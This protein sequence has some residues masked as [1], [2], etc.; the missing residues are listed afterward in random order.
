MWV[1]G[2]DVE[3]VGTRGCLPGRFGL[4][5]EAA[6]AEVAGAG[7]RQPWRQRLR[8]ERHLVEAAE[9]VGCLRE[10]RHGIDEAGIDP[11]WRRIGDRDRPADG[12]EQLVAQAKDEVV[13]QLGDDPRQAVDLA[14]VDA[15][16]A[17]RPLVGHAAERLHLD[18]AA[19]DAALAPEPVRPEHGRDGEQ[20]EHLGVALEL[21]HGFVGVAT[22]E[23][24]DG[25]FVVLLVRR[26]G[27][28]EQPG[29]FHLPG[30]EFQG[31]LAVLRT[32]PRP[33]SWPAAS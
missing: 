20:L 31:R 2:A 33:S 7:G 5:V 26:H 23:G 8:I 1:E 9:D 28:H 30:R 12:L 17:H 4:R 22:R 25:G 16:V 13:R 32:V 24:L 18:H 10:H 11:E 19:A 14:D 15:R 29:A 6:D 27:G 21:P 3:V